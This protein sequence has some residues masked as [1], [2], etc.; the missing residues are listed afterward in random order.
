MSGID[1]E[2]F[3]NKY[4]KPRVPVILEDYSKGWPAIKKW[5]YSYFKDLLGDTRVPLYDGSK[6]DGT[7]K[8]NEPAS[9][10]PFGEYLDLIQN[11]PTDL[12]IFLFNIFKEKPE[13]CNDFFK[14]ELT[15]DVLSH[16]PMMFFGGMGSTVFLHFDIDMSHVYHTHFGGKKEALLFDHQDATLLY[17][18]PFSVHNI[19]DIDIENPDL[20][21]WPAMKKLNGYRAE[22]GHGDTLFMPS[23]MWHHMKY[24]DAGF[25][26]SL[27]SLDKSLLT[28]MQGFYN[29]SILRQID[30]IGRKIAGPKWITYK[31]NAAIRKAEKALARS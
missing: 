21:Q 1:R 13:L 5:D 9:I 25:S 29:I 12:R 18:L 7:K 31:E 19:E 30:N 16:Y 28:K 17:R 8:V 22:L 14:P 6:A 4:Y 2:T 24:V 11:Q 27:R 3:L 26:L 23:G 20:E 15:P 10:M